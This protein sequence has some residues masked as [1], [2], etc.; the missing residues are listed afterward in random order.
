M[1]FELAKFNAVICYLTKGT[2]FSITV[3]RADVVSGPETDP[4]GHY[5]VFSINITEVFRG[6]SRGPALNA[7]KLYTPGNM[8][9]ERVT[10]PYGIRAGAEY[11]LHGEILKG[12]GMYTRFSSL[13][14]EWNNVTPQ[15]REKFQYYEAGCRQCQ[16]K[17][18]GETD[19]ECQK[20]LPGCE[21]KAN[22]LAPWQFLKSF[23]WHR[24]EHCE[25]DA[26]GEQCYWRKTDEPKECEESNPSSINSFQG[27][28][29]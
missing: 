4:E 6:L 17:L 20:K 26:T 3:I 10:G 29:A 7:T 2:I 12:V 18:C 27:V 23:C 9:T 16:L 5:E 25:V 15:E 24:Y 19:L 11:L 22:Q 1:S 13:R 21:M 14:K 8:S 28:E